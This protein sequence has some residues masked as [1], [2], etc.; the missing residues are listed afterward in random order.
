MTLTREER[1]ALEALEDFPRAPWAFGKLS[2]V[3]VAKGWARR[4]KDAD[5]KNWLGLSEAGKKALE[6]DGID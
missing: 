3:L 6:E 5:G 2:Q 1:A 4:V